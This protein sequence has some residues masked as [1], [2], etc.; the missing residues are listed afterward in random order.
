ML[1]TGGNTHLTGR[2]DAAVVVDGVAAHA[3][4]DSPVSPPRVELARGFLAGSGTVAT[5]DFSWTGGYQTGTGTTRIEPGGG[6]LAISG[7]AEHGLDQRRLEVA[8][9]AGATWTA[10]T[11]AMAGP[12]VIE[13]AGLFDVR[14]D[15]ELGG[16]CDSRSSVH[17][18]AGGTFR[19]RAGDGRARIGERFANDGTL[20]VASGTLDLA[21]GLDSFAGGTLRG[22]AYVV[23]GTLA[24]P[25]GPVERN[26]ATVVLDGAGSRVEDE[27]GDDQLRQ[28]ASNES[29]G[30][31]RVVNG[32]ELAPAGDLANAGS[33]DV[34]RDASLAPSG[35]Y[36]QSAG[37]TR[38]TMASAVLRPGAGG[39]GSGGPTVG[40]DGGSLEGDGTVDASVVSSGEVRPGLSTGVLSIAG[41]Y[42]QTAAGTLSTQV[43]D[44]V[45]HDRLDVAGTAH[46]AGAL[47]IET[48]GD[49]APA[50]ADELELVRHA[51]E[52]GEFDAV[53]GLEPAPGRA[54][55]PPDYDP[56]AVWLRPGTV[57][58]V[59]IG[60]ATAVEGDQGDATATFQVSVAPTPTRS[61][62]VDW[63]TVD[64]TATSPADF[65]PAGGTLT[66]PHGRST[67]EVKVPVHGDSVDEPD[68]R[69]GVELSSPTAATLGRQLGT[70]T[71]LDDDV[72]PPVK[73]PPVKPPP[74]K[75]PP[76]KP[77]P[78]KPPPACVD[79][80]APRSRLRAGRH[81]ARLRRGRL[82]VAGRASDRGCGGLARV[83]VAVARPRGHGRCRFLR[84]SGRLSHGRS[85]RRPLWLRAHGL[86]H[87]RLRAK[88][89]LPRGTYSVQTR[90]IDRAGNRELKRRTRPN[91]GRNY[92]IFRLR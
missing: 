62:R 13:N 73:P 86:A 56:A 43:A 49:F 8:T 1:F 16:C 14:G 64:G 4:F 29:T 5:P 47:R 25:G 90:A 24:F 92:A 59:S 87:W 7:D 84:R 80:L 9:G 74:V 91:R 12:S 11:I 34:G 71:I 81:P 33:I 48:L 58:V 36:V 6:G 21:G 32:R 41:D 42:T 82:T 28:L 44:T 60:D 57:P 38:L 18:A 89:R 31:L 83:R 3:T 77:P 10:G 68:E 61:V 63:R 65:G 50:P 76:V 27:S 22:G 53:Q 72:P 17:N 78:V 19:K 26:G 69:F 79:R 39:S 88:R 70:G 55:S 35:A 46:L 20:E 75:P 52:D 30:S 40:I 37:R 85:C 45:H 54:Y 66:I 2:V 67:G 15:L 51:A 23:R